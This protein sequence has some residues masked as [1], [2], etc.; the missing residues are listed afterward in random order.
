MARRVEYRTCP[1]C[2]A[3]CGLEL[4]LEAG[5]DVATDG[6]GPQ[7]EEIV[8]VRGDRDDVFSHGF[9]CPKGTALKQLESDPDR[10]RRPQVRRGDSWHEV[11]WDDAFAEVER[12]L[13]PIFERY[14]RDAVAMYMG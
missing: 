6:R 14:G 1:F 5:E 8:L 9:L 13:T 10:L 4:H 12:G 3:T 11:S 7:R 2:E